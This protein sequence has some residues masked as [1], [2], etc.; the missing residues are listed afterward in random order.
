MSEKQRQHEDYWGRCWAAALG[1]HMGAEVR[2]S[3]PDEDPPDID[4]HIRRRD[5]TVTTSWGEV[6][7]TYYDSNEAGWLWGSVPGNRGGYRE[8]DAVLGI[9]ARDLV[10]RKRK[11]YHE[12]VQRR[13]RGYLQVL[14]HSPLTTRSTR[15]EAEE[16]IRDML[17][18]GPSAEFEPFETVWLGYRLPWTIPEEKEDPKY[19]FR[20]VPDGD[21]FNFLKCIWTD[22]ALEPTDASED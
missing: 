1:K 5:G 3:R 4:F 2:S 15:V 16:A 19:A 9:R 14:L 18:T 7:G 22:P 13:G 6:T 11:K 12:L 10:E 8:P 20:D 21:R 17:E